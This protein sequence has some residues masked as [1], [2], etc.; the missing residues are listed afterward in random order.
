MSELKDIDRINAFSKR[1][2]TEEEVYIFTLTLCD[3]DIDRDY[4]CFSLDALKQ[5]KELFIG[6]T[7]IFDHSMKSA[8]Q[9]ARIF[10]TYIEKSDDELT[11]YGDGLYRLKARAYML[12]N[13]ENKTLIDEIEGGIKKEVSVS[14]SMEKAVCSVCGKDRR[15]E[16]C[17]HIGGKSYGGKLCYTTLS[18]ASD[19]YEF[20]FV[21]VPAQ[22]RAGVT[23]SYY[24]KE[25]NAL[26]DIIKAVRSDCEKLEL[27]AAQL[28]QLN[29]YI[30]SLEE[31]AT[32]GVRFKSELC[33]DVLKLFTEKVPEIER[34]VFSEIVSA[35]T[36]SELIAVK[37]SLVKSG[38]VPEPQ[39]ISAEGKTAKDYSQFRI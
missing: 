25:V 11:A 20:S 4:E 17:G 26:D 9:K 1:E 7:G 18:D 27:N 23:K 12:R 34:E 5:L 14:C 38:E 8:D 30:N 3:N 19:A 13:D 15:S 2:L 6:K 39:L 32:L 37:E 36:V 21:A 31:N 28:K 22:R 29:C 24:S 35:M 10:D 33:R 16:R